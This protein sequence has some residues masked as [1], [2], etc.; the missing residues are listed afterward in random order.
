VQNNR[1][2]DTMNDAPSRTIERLEDQINWHEAKSQSAQS[3]FKALKI[4]QLV[5]AG[6][7]P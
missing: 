6:L 7:I 1:D 5:C 3:W 2:T 4:V